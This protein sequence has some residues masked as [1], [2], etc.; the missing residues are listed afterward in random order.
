MASDA[1]TRT[2]PGCYRIFAGHCFDTCVY[3]SSSAVLKVVSVVPVNF[4]TCL[5][6]AVFYRHSIDG[7]ASGAGKEA[8]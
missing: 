2:M 3:K 7:R 6:W 4:F 8:F 1:Q 5:D